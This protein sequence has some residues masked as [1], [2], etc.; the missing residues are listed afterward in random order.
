MTWRSKATAI[1]LAATGLAGCGSN[2]NVPAL[3]AAHS[4][5]Q[6]SPNAVG[7]V[8][9]TLPVIVAP[10]TVPTPPPGES[11]GDALSSATQSI[12]GT[13]GSE[14][15]KAIALT[16]TTKG[17]QP[18]SDGLHCRITL[19]IHPGAHVLNLTTYASLDGS[20]EPLAVDNSYYPVTIV[21]GKNTPILGDFYGYA[22]SFTT[23]I[24]P[25]AVTQ[26][27]PA[28]VTA[29]LWGVDAA[30]KIIP[31]PAVYG[32]NGKVV[33]TKRAVKSGPYAAK[34]IHIG[35]AT[36][37]IFSDV[38]AYDG[39]LSGSE[40]FL[41]PG[42]RENAGVTY[43]S[44]TLTM[45]PGSPGV[46]Q[47]AVWPFGPSAT[48]LGTLAL[49]SA[50][51]N[52]NAPPWRTYIMEGPPISMD[53]TGAFWAGPFTT[54][55]QATGKTWIARYDN[56]GAALANVKPSSGLSFVG[57][58]TDSK[59]NL[60]A[61]QGTLKRRGNQGY[62]CPADEPELAMYS[63]SSG[64]TNVVR[65]VDLQSAQCPASVTVDRKGNTYVT[66]PY[67]VVDEYAP[68]VNGDAPPI[69]S[70]TGSTRSMAT[71]SAGDV[72]Q[73]GNYSQSNPSCINCLRKFAPGSNTPVY[74][75]PTVYPVAIAIDAHDNLYV[76]EEQG[77]F[78]PNYSIAVYPPGATTPTRT[79]AGPNTGLVQP[80]FIAVSR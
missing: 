9:V 78:E 77:E 27:F 47:I 42:S 46:A 62:I 43:G 68:N 7:T 66:R 37:A 1:A 51:A 61:V 19:R 79:I 64:Y 72:Y 34:D 32:T 33:T 80:E 39:R 16:A 8:S 29:S 31:E 30:G 58:A 74:I 36:N 71:D 35:Y 23:T 69:R 28:N 67:G 48:R 70:F 24:S 52:G 25:A 75:L 76:L 22:K 3:Q 2:A 6:R 53:V 18:E 57:A 45:N 13:F 56:S 63:A 44:A 60:F 17:C 73:A 20:G 54:D 50:G 21:A 15:L 11:G 12:A 49:F 14:K 55:Q 41:F 59:Q 26:G 40:T 4:M 10:N 65:A 38:L 5:L